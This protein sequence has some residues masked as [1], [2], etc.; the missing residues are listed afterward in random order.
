MRRMCLL[1]ACCTAIHLWAQ[2]FDF[3]LTSP[4]PV[5]N[6]ETGYGYDMTVPPSAS[7]SADMPWPEGTV[8]FS[9][10]VP[11]GNY[12]VSV[13]IGSGKRSAETMVRAESRRLLLEPVNTRKGERL[14]YTFLVNKRSPRIDANRNIKIKERERD[15]LNWDD[16]LTLEF[17]GAFPAVERIRIERDSISPTL[18]LCG[19]STV[20]DQE[21][22]PWASWG[23]MI[24]RWLDDG[25]A[26]ANYAE[27]GLTATTFL[28]QGRLDKILTT[29][30]AGDCVVCEFG[31]NDQ[32]ERFPGAGAYANFSYALKQFIDKVRGKG[33]DIVFVT[34]TQRRSFD[35]SHLR[36][37]ETHGDYPDAM[38]DMACREHVPVI[39][40]HDMTRVFFETLGYEG[41]KRALVHYPRGSF[42]G[43]EKDLADNTHFNPYGAYE[44]AKMVVS[45]AM[46]L[47]LPFVSH[48]RS[49]WKDYSPFLPDRQ[50]DFHWYAA[51]V[52]ETL[53]P[54]GN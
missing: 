40:L 35:E 13:T 33:A 11:D 18:Y 4:Q 38:R 39:E 12:R 51:P 36:I 22:E 1:L 45:A 29:L 3:D 31:H 16:R 34:P 17:N 15:Y 6:D 24:P 26:V 49:D 5:Y 20:V 53:R 9:V 41:S 14:T 43:Q 27:S 50:E 48:L 46:Q 28:A 52:V 19:N 2:S 10:K 23:Q 30:K 54:D 21:R 7:T 32:K 47:R 25:I 8:Y 37:V 42:P 44:V